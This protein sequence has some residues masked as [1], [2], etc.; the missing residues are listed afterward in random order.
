MV[1]GRENRECVNGALRYKRVGVQGYTRTCY[2]DVTHNFQDRNTLT[3]GFVQ[4]YDIF[5]I[6]DFRSSFYRLLF[7][8]YSI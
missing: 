8:R 7:H 3:D 5:M 4:D 1:N 6:T 2:P